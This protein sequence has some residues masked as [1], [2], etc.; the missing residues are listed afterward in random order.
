MLRILRE[1]E[2]I[3]LLLNVTIYVS[4]FLN[5][6]MYVY[7]Q[8]INVRLNLLFHD[9]SFFISS[10]VQPSREKDI[11]YTY[12]IWLC[13]TH[14]SCMIQDSL[15]YTRPIISST[16]HKTSYRDGSNASHKR[17]IKN[18]LPVSFNPIITYFYPVYLH[19]Q[20]NDYKL[21]IIIWSYPKVCS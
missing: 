16:F 11:L 14:K 12:Y 2:L 3:P 13:P 20:L 19:F 4:T 10:S 18:Q 15:L 21:L 9:F 8:Y 5:T 1:F 17:L 7:V 6:Y